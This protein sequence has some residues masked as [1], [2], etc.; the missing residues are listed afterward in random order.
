MRSLR[1][2]TS[3]FLAGLLILGL[4]APA[5]QARVKGKEFSIHTAS[6]RPRTCG[7]WIGGTPRSNG[8]TFPDP[9][10]RRHGFP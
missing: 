2:L 9:V 8:G 5:A 4:N 1:L 3:L 7:S 6:S 10:A